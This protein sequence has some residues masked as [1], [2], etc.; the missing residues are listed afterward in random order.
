MTN[1]ITTFKAKAHS[2][3]ITAA[4]MI[5]LCIYKTMKAKSEDKAVILKH[6]L[7]KAF[8]A[9]K[10]CGH[11]LYPY[12][13]ITNAM[14]GFDWQL[15]PGKRY[16]IDGTWKEVSGFVLGTEVTN[17]LSDDE[18]LTF[19]ELAAMITPDFVRVL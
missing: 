15:R 3:S 16:Q 7:K 11:R 5:A 19:R 14:Y 2:K 10:M 18:L 4:D 9:G 13:A 12:Q 6:F 8:S 1:F 17:V